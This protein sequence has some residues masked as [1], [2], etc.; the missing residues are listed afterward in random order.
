MEK[1]D[2][3]LP[4][5]WRPHVVGAGPPT[6]ELFILIH[7]T[8]NIYLTKLPWIADSA[9]AFLI[10]CHLVMAPGAANSADWIL[11]KCRR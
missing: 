9:A 10:F 8:N 6:R 11:H 3:V 7:Q 1:V 5:V 4:L 2:A